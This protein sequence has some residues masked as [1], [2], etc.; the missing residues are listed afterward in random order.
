MESLNI[1]R[2]IEIF[3]DDVLYYYYGYFYYNEFKIV[4][5]NVCIEKRNDCLVGKNI[6]MKKN[7]NN[8][9]RFEKEVGIY[10]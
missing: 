5:V 2:N 10:L 3:C 1:K 6:L 4:V 8:Y 7:N 9:G